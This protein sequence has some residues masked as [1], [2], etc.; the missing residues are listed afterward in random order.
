M[1]CL[2]GYLFLP[3]RVEGLESKKW[4][5]RDKMTSYSRMRW[6]L[7]DGLILTR[8]KQFIEIN[9]TNPQVHLRITVTLE[10]SCKH[11]AVSVTLALNRIRLETTFATCIPR[12]KVI[13]RAQEVWLVCKIQADDRENKGIL[14]EWTDALLGI[15]DV[16]QGGNAISPGS[17]WKYPTCLHKVPPWEVTRAQ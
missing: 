4:E 5:D 17:I 15:S 12:Y 8:I 2:R 3:D 9:V 1:S 10:M 13:Q 6:P 7:A 16:A 11:C 14:R